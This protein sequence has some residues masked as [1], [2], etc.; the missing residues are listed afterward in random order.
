MKKTNAMTG[1]SLRALFASGTGVGLTL[2]ASV[3]AAVAMALMPQ[4]MRAQ[5]TQPPAG[6]KVL[7][8]FTKGAPT[9]AENTIKLVSG[10]KIKTYKEPQDD[11][12]IIGQRRTMEI[13]LT[14][15]ANNPY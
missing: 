4:M 1:F 8:D 9:A 11:G 13:F 2:R 6:S 5:A 7:D 15:A 10:D 3:L 12:H 14:P